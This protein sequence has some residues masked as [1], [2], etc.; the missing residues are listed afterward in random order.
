MSKSLGNFYTLRD[1]IAKRYDPLA[2][3]YLALGAHYRSKLNF[4]W[5]AI[6]TA[7]TTLENLYEFM[8]R[9]EREDSTGLEGAVERA[10]RTFD[11]AIDDD[12]NTPVALAAVFG[13]IREVNVHGSGGK[14]VFECMEDFDRVL[15][16]KLAERAKPVTAEIPPEIESLVEEREKA[17]KAKDFATSDRI[18]DEL[19]AAGYV[20]EDTPQG[21]RLKA[22]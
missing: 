9:L 21:P 13:L 20:I 3:R 18:R 14:E 8:G 7:K 2:F 15:G 11:G 17:R 12:L 19:A 5:Q 10:R 22:K 6:E 1:V 4:T 16:L